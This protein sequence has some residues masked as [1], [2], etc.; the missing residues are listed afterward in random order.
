M[1]GYKKILKNKNLRFFI[2]NLLRLVP[3]QA[4]VKAEYYIKLKKR[5]DLKNPETFTEKIQWYKLFYRDEQMVRC[6]DKNTV[7]GYVAEKGVGSILNE[8]YCVFQKPEEI[9][10]TQL[11]DQFVLKLSNGSGTNYIC[12]DKST[13]D[14]D[15]IVNRFR[16]YV[17]QVKAN[18]GREWPYT[19]AEPV[20]VAERLLEDLTAEN[21]AVKDYKILCFGGV[22]EYIICVSDRYTDRCNHLVYDP[23]WVNQHIAFEGARPDEEAEK[24]ENLDRMLEIAAILSADFPFARIDLY[25]LEGSIYFGEITFFPWSGYMEFEP[26]EFDAVLGRRFTLPKPNTGA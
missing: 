1:D 12:R 8:Q 9:D 10:F 5:L 25:S 6:A 13:A 24:P 19:K 15:Q 14:R 21:H 22:P 26:K 17:F 3:D 7:R 20:I 4:M 18:A 23:N 16:S 2:L 11:P